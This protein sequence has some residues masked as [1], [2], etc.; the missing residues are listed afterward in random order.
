MLYNRMT[1]MPGSHAYTE[2]HRLTQ[3]DHLKKILDPIPKLPGIYIMKD[4]KG[5]MLYIGKAKSL[6]HRV[7]S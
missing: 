7:R 3:K 5:D 2:D 4:G 6:F 1:R